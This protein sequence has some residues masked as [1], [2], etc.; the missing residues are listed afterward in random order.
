MTRLT[1]LFL[2]GSA[3]TLAVGREVSAQPPNLTAD[4]PAPGQPQANTQTTTGTVA[5]VSRTTL[6]VRTADG[7]TRLFVL[8]ADTTKPSSIPVGASVTV[9]S[10][11]GPDP[12]APM[13]VSVTVVAPPTKPAPGEK[14]AADEPIP[15]AVRRLEQSLA[16]QSRRFNLGVRAGV[17][18]DPELVVIGGHV[19]FG[20]FFSERLSAR[21]SVDLGFGEVTDLMALNF[22]AIYR[23]PPAPGRNWAFYGGAGPGL[24]FSKRGFEVEGEEGEEGEEDEEGFDFDDFDLDVGLN[25]VAGFRARSG[26]FIEVRTGAYSKPVLRF[27]VGFNF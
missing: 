5:S 8:G 18:L 21:P 4:I 22:E 7:Q 14:T 19:E 24:N 6:I 20:P 23:L 2:I 9:T 25:I 12:D 10:T 17:G 11:P 1:S 15:P 27:V 13:A 3:L 16:R 26:T